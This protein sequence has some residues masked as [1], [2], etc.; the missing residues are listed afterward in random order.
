MVAMRESIVPVESMTSEDLMEAMVSTPV[1]HQT[2]PQTL[3]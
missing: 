3:M 1:H 2:V